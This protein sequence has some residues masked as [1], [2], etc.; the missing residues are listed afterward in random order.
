MCLGAN[1]GGRS[2]VRAADA[3]QI[4]CAARFRFM[5]GRRCRVSMISVPAPAADLDA[6]SPQ[7]AGHYACEGMP[8]IQFVDIRRIS[9]NSASLSGSG[10][11]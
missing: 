5:L 11:R 7:Q 2:S 6:L 3:V 4:L 8:Q 10:W 9:F 1:E